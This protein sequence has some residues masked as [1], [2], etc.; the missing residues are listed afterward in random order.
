[1]QDSRDITAPATGVRTMTL[2]RPLWVIVPLALWAQSLPMPN[3]K[4]VEIVAHMQGAEAAQRSHNLVAA[5]DEYRK[6]I[7]LDPSR[8][9]AHTRLGMAYQDLGMPHEAASSFER[10]LH[11]DPR[12]TGVG[13]LLAS[14][15]FDMG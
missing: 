13:V 3:V 12:L 1:M 7:E 8:A 11:L 10:A 14:V 4:D 6:I 9:E 5:V 2:L 15:Y